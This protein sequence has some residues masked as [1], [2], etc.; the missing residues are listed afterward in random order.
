MIRVVATVARWTTLLV[1]F[2]RTWIRAVPTRHIATN[3]I[4][5]ALAVG[6][7]VESF[8][9]VSIRVTMDS[10]ITSLADSVVYDVFVGARVI[11]PDGGALL[12]G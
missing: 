12:A 3:G 5:N 7:A 1:L 11:Q 6:S 2:P 4:A 9:G 10:S 8:N